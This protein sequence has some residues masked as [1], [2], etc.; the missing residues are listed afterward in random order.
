[1]PTE[2]ELDQRVNESLDSSQKELKTARAAIQKTEL[3]Y[4]YEYSKKA[5]ER[6]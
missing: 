1:M 4:L 2:D 6:E 5:G 3:D